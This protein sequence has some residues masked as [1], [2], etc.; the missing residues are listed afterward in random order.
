MSGTERLI[1]KHRLLSSPRRTL[2]ELGN[3]LG[4]TRERVRQI[5][6]RLA[7]KIDSYIGSQLRVIT[8]LARQRLSPVIA[9]GDLD[10]R[11]IELFFDHNDREAVELAG[12]LLKNQLDYPCEKEVCL[13]GEAM[14]LV[15][16]LRQAARLSADEVGLIDETELPAQLP[17]AEWTLHW[18]A[19]FERCDFHLLFG[20]PALR[21][22]GKARVKAALLSIGQPATR[23]E[24]AQLCGITPARVSSHL[25]VIPGVARADR[26]R[27][28]LVE[29]IDDKYEGI[30]A[31]IIQRVEED[32][33]ATKLNRLLDELPRLF[34][35]S[36]ISVRAYVSTS[37]FVVRDGYVSVADVSSI[38]FRDLN[39]VI[40]GR[41]AA[42]NPYWTFV[43]ED[44]YFD[45]YSLTNLPRELA[46]ALG[47]QPNDKTHI[48][49]A[50]LPG[51]GELSV[52]WRLSSTSGCYLGYLAEPLRR[53]RVSKGDRVRLV[54]KGRGLVELHRDAPEGP[55]QGGGAG[56]TA[57]LVL[58]RI[59][60]RRRVL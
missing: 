59:K 12:T 49:V 2:Q 24:L 30:A 29:W 21:D 38:V 46:K 1:L 41:D 48:R 47:C 27:W 50:G 22:T 26:D 51:G 36:K 7:D 4:V 18:Q 56:K 31:E 44:R 37:Q 57:D 13:N 39:D 53:L 20:R 28:G 58:E 14:L 33:G 5:Q 16:E 35:V 42:G 19:L 17:G 23:E 32:G 60:S 52:S 8:T 15:E 3:Q 43:V 9:A 11:I 25:S 10:D 45:G 54:I 34:G 6:A 55:S 40:D